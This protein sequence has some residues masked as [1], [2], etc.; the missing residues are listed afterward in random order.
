MFKEQMILGGASLLG[1]CMKILPGFEERSCLIHRITAEWPQ[2]A[3]VVYKL[4]YMLTT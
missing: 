2:M 3:L 4:P 1:S